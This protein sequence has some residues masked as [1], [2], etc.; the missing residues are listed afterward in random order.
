MLKMSEK[1]DVRTEISKNRMYIVLDGF[2]S[3]DEAKQMADALVAAGKKLMPGFT[4]I[5]D[6]R[7]LKPLTPAGLDHLQKA[8]SVLRN[9][10]VKRVIR[11]VDPKNIT[12]KMQFARLG[13][14][15]YQDSKVQNFTSTVK[16]AEKLLDADK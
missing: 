12:T 1:I 6:I 4:I 9:Q 7:E 11:V 8:Q 14:D 2:L 15:A 3:D 13:R 16:E 10:G 5:N